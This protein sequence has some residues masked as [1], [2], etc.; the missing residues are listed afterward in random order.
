VFFYTLPVGATIRFQTPSTYSHAYHEIRYDGSCPG[1]TQAQC[2]SASSDMSLQNTRS[3]SVDVY[4]IQSGFST[5]DDYLNVQWTVSGIGGIGGSEPFLTRVSDLSPCARC[6]VMYSCRSAMMLPVS[7]DVRFLLRSP[8]SSPT[9]VYRIVAMTDCRV[10]RCRNMLQPHR[11][12][13]R[14]LSLLGHHCRR[15]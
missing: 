6:G 2:S 7:A 12:Q 10:V 4:Y 9:R 14:E 8:E 3:S 5:A 11:P 1:S 13:R 15:D